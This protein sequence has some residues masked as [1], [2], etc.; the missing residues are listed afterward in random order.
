VNGAL[1]WG[2]GSAYSSTP[3][4]TRLR[5]DP[6]AQTSL[7]LWPAKREREA[8]TTRFRLHNK[9]LE[10][11]MRELPNSRSNSRSNSPLSLSPCFLYTRG[12]PPYPLTFLHRSRPC[13]KKS[14]ASSTEQSFPVLNVMGLGL[15]VHCSVCKICFAAA[16]RD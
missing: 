5:N 14:S 12:S 11:D 1:Q 2:W 15:T 9:R 6:V 4:G 13:T 3:R 7:V 16:T 10:R 8:K